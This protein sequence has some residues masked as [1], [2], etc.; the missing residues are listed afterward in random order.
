MVNIWQQ[1]VV[2][3]FLQFKVK[4]NRLKKL[5]RDI[6]RV[7]H[8]DSL[9]ALMAMYSPQLMTTK[10][11][12][13]IPSPRNASNW[14]LSTKKKEEDSELVEPQLYLPFLQINTLELLLLVA[15]DSSQLVQMMEL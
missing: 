3:K 11:Y 6:H 1:Q 5:C 12:A 9:L 14:V 7:K 10:L 4:P 13:S 8:G 2:E 15:K